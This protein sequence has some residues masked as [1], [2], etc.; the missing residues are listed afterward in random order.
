MRHRLHLLH[1]YPKYAFTTNKMKR[2]CIKNGRIVLPDRIEK[3]NIIAEDG[4]I[5]DVCNFIPEDCA[6]IDAAGKIVTPG[7]VELHA[8]GA[9]GSDFCDATAEAFENV[10][11]THLKHGA[12]LICPTAVS[13]TAD[14][15][16]NL[17]DIYRMVKSQSLGGYMHKLHLEGP[18]LNVN[19]CGA[20]RPDIIRC[21]SSCE[22][23]A[24]FDSAS[25]I[26]GRIGCAPEIDGIDYLAKKAV[27]NGIMLS[28]AHSGATAE[29]T[30]RAI[31]MGFTHVTHLYSGTTTV[32]KINQRV[33]AGILEAAYL[34]DNINIELIGDGRHVAKETM[35]LALKIKS[36][37]KINLTSDSMRAAGQVGVSESY[38]G[39]ICPEN[40]V[41]IDDGVAKL[42]DMS[43]YAGSIA[44]ADRMLQNAVLNYGISVTDAVNMLSA[45]PSRIIGAQ[46]K[47]SISAGKDCDIVIWNEDF[48]V[49]DIIAK[50]EII[51]EI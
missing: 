47:G 33:C 20:Q 18:F 27:E 39:D 50:G 26:I 12:T 46:K 43:S 9:G 11:K 7:L 42:P 34:Y 19:M 51:D 1:R 15:L 25:D 41:I 10:V 13:C 16:F 28:I 2:I 36:S 14:K 4:I 5:A 6:V 21:P 49:S 23:D 44:T 8:H 31:D 35:Q 37:D 17:F 29:Q 45:T 3:L 30:K 40:R 24:I 38:L 22:V 48:T 32:R